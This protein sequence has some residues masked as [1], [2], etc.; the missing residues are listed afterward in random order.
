MYVIAGVTGQTGR[1]VAETLLEEGRPVTVIVRAAANGEAWRAKGANVAV[2]ELGDA[3]AMQRAL[4]GATGAYLLLPP[5]YGAVRYLDDR[6]RLA[7]AMAKAV[8]ASKIPH[9]VLLSSIGAQQVSGT[10]PIA[11]VRYAETVMAPA[12]GRLTVIRASY[13]LENW[14]TVLGSAKETGILPS[15]LTPQRKIPMVA[16]RDIGR[17]AAQSLTNPPGGLRVIELAGP[18][19]YSPEDI[20]QT[21]GSLVNREVRVQA[22]PISAVVPTFTSFGFS[23]N[24]ARLFEEMYAGINSGH[25]AFEERGTELHRGTVTAGEVFRGLLGR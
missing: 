24:A 21:V 18:R 19:A 5:N 3:A 1:A 4:A 6:Q 25:V 16:T 15:F 13:F 10:G 22:A 11:T 12:V 14:A 17:V 23:E 20:G 2:A 7:D 9:V 8:A